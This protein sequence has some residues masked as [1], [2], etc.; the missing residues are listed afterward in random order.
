MSAAVWSQVDAGVALTLGVIVETAA[1]RKFQQPRVIALTLER[2]QP[3]LVGRRG[4]ALRVGLVV[5]GYEAVVGAGV[6]A[7]RGGVGFGFSCALLVAC[8]AFL[9]AL[10]RAVQQSVP[11]AC[12]G[13]LGRTAAGGREVGRGIVLVAGAAFLVVHR[14]I[15]AGAGYGAGPIALLAVVGTLL[16]I[17]IGRG[18]GAKVRPG[19]EIDV[20]PGAGRDEHDTRAGG[21]RRV[22]GYDS[23]LYTS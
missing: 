14:A 12:F 21:L 13:R 11:C 9:L 18:I 8:S 10:T 22:A 6:V 16:L 7:F 2:L 23:D 1:I 15:A 17:V 4:L 3:E 19:L 5:A 20:A